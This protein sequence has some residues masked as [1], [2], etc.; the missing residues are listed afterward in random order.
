MNDSLISVIIPIYNAEKTLKRC[1]DSLLNQTY[2]NLELLLIDDGSTDNSNKICKKFSLIDKRVK[3]LKKDNGGVSS[4][5]NMGLKVATGDFIAFVDSDD[6]VEENM[7]ELLINNLISNKADIAICNLFYEDINKK[8]IYRFDHKN[9]MFDKTDYP[10]LSYYKKCISGY[11]CNKLYS[12]KII[13]NDNNSFIRFNTDI[14]IAEDDLFNYKLLEKNKFIKYIYINDKL[15][16]YVINENSATNCT[17]NLNKLSYF[18]AK[19]EEIDILNNLKISSDFLMADYV[20][21]QIKSYYFAN[22]NQV[23]LNEEY[24]NIENKSKKYYRILNKSNLKIKLRIKLFLIVHF[25]KIYKFKK[26]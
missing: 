3:Y 16:H 1:I 10:E 13:Y 15:Y 19:N 21:N 18:K 2:S 26:R 8:I 12:K 4:A 23:I 20:I 5:R 11:V 7:F 6:Y 22:K 25:P 17:F 24:N 14:T 9:S